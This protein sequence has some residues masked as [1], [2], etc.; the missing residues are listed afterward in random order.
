M[1][2]RHSPTTLTL[3]HRVSYRLVVLALFVG[4]SGTLL[5]I[6]C[7]T[8]ETSV[9]QNPLPHTFPDLPPDTSP[10]RAE[11]LASWKEHERQMAKEFPSPAPE[12]PLEKTQIEI[13]SDPPGAR[14]E[15]N[16]HYIGDAHAGQARAYCRHRLPA[17][18]RP[19]NAKL[20]RHRS[21]HCHGSRATPVPNVQVRIEPG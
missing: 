10:T 3:L 20:R 16:G 15:V 2:L 1:L 19:T 9:Q 4:A 7:S 12:P 14:I 11:I 6:G 17:N 13:I 5:L 8:P 18:V 21:S